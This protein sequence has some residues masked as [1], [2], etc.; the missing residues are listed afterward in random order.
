[1]TDHGVTQVPIDLGQV[2]I[3]LIKF[4]VLGSFET[5][6]IPTVD[7]CNWRRLRHAGNNKSNFLVSNLVARVA[8]FP[9]G[10]RIIGSFAPWKSRVERRV[11]LVDQ[12]VRI[13]PDGTAFSIFQS[14][15]HVY[16]DFQIGRKSGGN[17]FEYSS[18]VRHAGKKK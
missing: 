14:A 18:R 3:I 13:N 17:F 1:M 6:V 16:A 12:F 7:L 9:P 8:K 2:K 4:R 10:A 15:L 5:F 11:F